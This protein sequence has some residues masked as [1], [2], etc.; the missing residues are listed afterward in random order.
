VGVE[1]TIVGVGGGYREGV[2]DFT[3]RF[4][5]ADSVSRYVVVRP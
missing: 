5:F 3:S 2:S 4:H 1:E